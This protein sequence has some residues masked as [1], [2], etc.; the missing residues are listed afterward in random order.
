MHIIPSLPQ[1]TGKT[2]LFY[3]QTAKEG[4]E[5]HFLI[6]IGNTN[7]MFADQVTGALDHLIWIRDPQ[8]LRTLQPEKIRPKQPILQGNS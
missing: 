4:R 7:L 2:F 3:S 6:D 8:I 1:K 5:L